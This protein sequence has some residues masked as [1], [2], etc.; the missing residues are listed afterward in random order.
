MH[1]DHG[2]SVQKKIDAE[3]NLV[4]ARLALIK[5]EEKMVIA[6]AQMEYVAYVDDLERKLGAMKA[7]AS[8][9]CRS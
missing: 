8:R 7:R 2:R 3:L 9:I 4:Q 5:G 6:N 1:Y